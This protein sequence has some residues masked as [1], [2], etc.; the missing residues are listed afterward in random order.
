MGNYNG[1]G[2]ANGTLLTT[3]NKEEGF[4]ER[5]IAAG[6]RKDFIIVFKPIMTSPDQQ[7]L[8]GAKR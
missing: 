5:L 3:I 2:A 6:L 4:M 1:N 8:I 7:V